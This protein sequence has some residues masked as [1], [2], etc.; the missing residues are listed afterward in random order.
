MRFCI[1]YCISL[2]YLRSTCIHISKGLVFYLLLYTI[3]ESIREVAA[4]NNYLPKLPS[5]L[6]NTFLFRASAMNGSQS[7]SL[8]KGEEPRC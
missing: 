1:Y 4:C 7:R 5:N 8:E 3:Y 6:G 2:T